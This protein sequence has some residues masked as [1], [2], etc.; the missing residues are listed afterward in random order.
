[1]NLELYFYE[2]IKSLHLYSRSITCQQLRVVKNE[3]LQSM[4]L[5]PKNYMTC[6]SIEFVSYAYTNQL[7]IYT[8]NNMSFK[9]LA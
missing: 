8:R 9:L 6:K 4:K 1:M 7:L 2:T 5:H 3:L